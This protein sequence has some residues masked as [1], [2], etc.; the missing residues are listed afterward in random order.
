MT[1][2]KESKRGQRAASAPGG[3]QLVKGIA[4][5]ASATLGVGATF[6]RIAAQ[7]TAGERPVP[8]PSEPG[9]PLTAIVH[10]SAAAL[11]NVVDAVR[12]GMDEIR[13]GTG[14]ASDT[15]RPP[16]AAPPPAAA[17]ASLPTV[18]PD[19]TLRMPLSIENTSAEPMADLHFLCLALEAEASG[20][21]VPLTATN[22]RFEPTLLSV[23]PRDFEKL[24]VYV[25]VPADAAAG[26]YVATIGLE[27]GSFR[28]G[29]PFV[30]APAESG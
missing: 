5:L 3:E 22:V 13:S 30:V 7:A 12:A 26:R 19:S 1:Q 14:Q 4:D 6:A 11:V 2:Q 28:T 9:A 18:H 24:T 25:D 16:S 27:N 17:P 20:S 29:F 21:G 10:Y 8:P 23:A 15:S